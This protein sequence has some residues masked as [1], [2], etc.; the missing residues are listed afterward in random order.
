MIEVYGMNGA[1][2][3]LAQSFGEAK[4]MQE[5]SL[6]GDLAPFYYGIGFNGQPLFDADEMPEDLMQRYG[7]E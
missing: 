5:A 1:R 7:L 2:L 6:P 4:R 3:G